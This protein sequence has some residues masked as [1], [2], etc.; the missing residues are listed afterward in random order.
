[1]RDLLLPHEGTLMVYNS[2]RPGGPSGHP[3]P[4]LT[5]STSI[6]PRSLGSASL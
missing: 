1:M 6:V 2:P 4:G 5:Q 3:T